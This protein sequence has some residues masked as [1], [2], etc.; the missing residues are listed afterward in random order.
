MDQTQPILPDRQISRR[1]PYP[2]A[3]AQ[4]VLLMNFSED[5]AEVQVRADATAEALAEVQRVL[6]VPLQATMLQP[7]AFDQA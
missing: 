3:K 4:G 5:V 2:F 1:I 7:D 6:G